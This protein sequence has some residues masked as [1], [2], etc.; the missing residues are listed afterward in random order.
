MGFI[1]IFLLLWLILS[2]C[3][4]SPCYFMENEIIVHEMSSPRSESIETDE[5]TY[6]QLYI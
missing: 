4:E 5:Y 1:F 6:L 2:V 3:W